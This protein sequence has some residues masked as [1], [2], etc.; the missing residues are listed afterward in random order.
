M[1][2]ARPTVTRVWVWLVALSLLGTVVALTF[3]AGSTRVGT[4]VGLLALT[5]IKARLILPTI[6]AWRRPRSGMEVP[7][8]RSRSSWDC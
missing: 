1:T 3:D 7:Y 6:C 5:L 8:W 2:A 4:G